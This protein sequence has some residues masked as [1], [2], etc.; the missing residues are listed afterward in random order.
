MQSGTAEY[1]GHGRN[2]GG[3]QSHSI[4]EEYPCMVAG[5]EGAGRKT[6]WYGYNLI[7]GERG[8]LR[9]EYGDAEADCYRMR[10]AWRNRQLQAE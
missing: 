10:D 7:T 3:L 8:E 9:E 5:T 1:K 4:G 6:L 2:T